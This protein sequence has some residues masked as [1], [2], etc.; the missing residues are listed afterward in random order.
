MPKLNHPRGRADVAHAGLPALVSETDPN[1]VEIL[2]DEMAPVV[3]QV[4]QRISDNLAASNA[5][6][7][8]LEQGIMDQVQQ[9]I[10]KGPPPMPAM[11][12]QNVARDMMAQSAR[13]ALRMVQDPKMRRMMIEQYRAAGIEIDD[14]DL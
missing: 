5:Q 2:W 8:E 1:D 7:A 10:A 11:P 9:A 14:A 3:D 13:Q 12:Q 4:G 6:A